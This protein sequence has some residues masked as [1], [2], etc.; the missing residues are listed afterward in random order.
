MA[1]SCPERTVALWEISAG[2]CRCSCFAPAIEI[3]TDGVWKAACSWLGSG[4]RSSETAWADAATL[5]CRHRCYDRAVAE[6]ARTMCGS[7]A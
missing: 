2:A 4:G 5:R 7:V 6:G 1:L 3:A